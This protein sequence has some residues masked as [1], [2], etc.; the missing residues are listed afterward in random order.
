M[1]TIE[2]KYMSA[3]CDANVWVGEREKGRESRT[4]QRSGCQQ[5]QEKQQHQLNKLMCLCMCIWNASLIVINIGRRKNKF[6]FVWKLNNNFHTVYF[7]E[8]CCLYFNWNAKKIIY[9]SASPHPKSFAA[10]W[11]RKLENEGGHCLTWKKPLRYKQIIGEKHRT[12]APLIDITS[13]QIK[14]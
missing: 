13:T 4:E 7:S 1:F 11:T 6:L 8:K 9:A 5:K 10:A 2:W 14:Q 12:H 3:V